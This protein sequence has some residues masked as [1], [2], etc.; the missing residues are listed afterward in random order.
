MTGSDPAL[1]F[2]AICEAVLASKH[3]MGNRAYQA[4]E[5]LFASEERREG[6]YLRSLDR[7]NSGGYDRL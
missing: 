6:W 3:H 7:Q 4:V 5:S 2:R 1:R